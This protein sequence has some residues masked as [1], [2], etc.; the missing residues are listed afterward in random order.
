MKCTV[1]LVGGA[2]AVLAVLAPGIHAELPP[3]AYPD[4]KLASEDLDISV[5]SSSKTVTD[6]NDILTRWDVEVIAVVRAV[7]KSGT[8][9]RE[10]SRIVIRYSAH[11]YKKRDWCGPG[12]Q[13]ILSKGESWSAVLNAMGEQKERYYVPGGA[14]YS[15]FGSAGKK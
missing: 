11:R 1:F 3:S 7:R 14:P 6:N 15:T 4:P 8:G 2:L 13:P 5:L 9:L 10:E 12:S